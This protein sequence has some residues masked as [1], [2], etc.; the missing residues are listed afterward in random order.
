MQGEFAH[1]GV[2]DAEIV[3]INGAR[4][5]IEVFGEAGRPTLIAHHGAP[6][7]SSRA[8]PRAAFGPLADEFRVVVYDARGCGD[9]ELI[10]PYTNE[11]WV[12][13]LDAVREWLG[14]EKVLVAGGSY[15]GFIA[16]EYAF[17]HPERTLGVVLR[18]TAPDGEHREAGAE[19]ALASDRTD[20]DLETWHRYMRGGL[21]SD[22]DLRQAWRNLLPLYNYEFKPEE[23]EAQIAATPFRFETQNAAMRNMADFD[24]KPRLP[25][26]T[27]PTLVTVGRH[28]WIAQPKYSEQIADLIPN[29]RLHIFERSGHSPQIEQAEEFRDVVRAFLREVSGG[30]AR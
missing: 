28:D 27:A 2:G 6:G 9:S 23:I 11:Q 19:R 8:E 7:L 30:I 13:D 24:L 22:D 25:E 12:A 1:A 20:F 4:L 5:A 17:T 16:L 26:I 21:T 3:E 18:N 15:G 29:S 10:G 14:E